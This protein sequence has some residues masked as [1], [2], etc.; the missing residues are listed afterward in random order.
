MHGDADELCELGH[1]HL[2]KDRVSAGQSANHCADRARHPHPPL[3]WDDRTLK[4]AAELLLDVLVLGP[5]PLVVLE[6]LQGVVVSLVEEDELAVVYDLVDEVVEES[7][8]GVCARASVLEVPEPLKRLPAKRM[9][10][11]VKLKQDVLLAF[12][13][14]VE[15]CLC[16]A[17]PLSDVAQRRLVVTLL[18]EQLER[19]V[20]NAL[21]RRGA[22]LLALSLFSIS[23]AS[24]L[25]VRYFYAC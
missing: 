1:R 11:Q 13:V 5:M 4:D 6:L 10:S 3:E 25:L 2:T 7:R 18:G 17:K 8:P 12:E 21:T 24:P 16:G 9:K 14:I 22:G 23:R 15:R 20:E 19:D